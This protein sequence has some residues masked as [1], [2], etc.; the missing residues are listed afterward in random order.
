VNDTLT[1]SL[2]LNTFVLAEEMYV[3]Q[4]QHRKTNTHESGTCQKLAYTLLLLM[5]NGDS[6]NV[7]TAVGSQWKDEW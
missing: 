7:K 6:F 2:C 4:S 3:N 1:P 5:M